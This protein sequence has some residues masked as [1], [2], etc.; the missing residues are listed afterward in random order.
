M[1]IQIKKDCIVG[2]EARKAGE[3]VLID[4]ARGEKMIKR[5]FATM[6]KIVKSKIKLKE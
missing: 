3:F 5:G 2:G 6:L 4:Q 1:E